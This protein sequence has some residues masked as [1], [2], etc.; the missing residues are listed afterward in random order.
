L[1][2]RALALLLAAGA[3]PL[4]SGA[5][6]G[7]EVTGEVVGQDDDAVD[8]RIGLANRSAATVSAV[9]AEAELF[10]HVESRKLDAGLAPGAASALLFSLPLA[11]APPG[12]HAVTLRLEYQAGGTPG[13]PQRTHVQPAYVLLALGEN[14]AP[15]VRLTAPEAHMD[16]VGRWRVGL[17]SIDGAAH[18]VRLRVVLPRTLRADPVDSL[19]DVPASGRID[20][21][22]LLFRVDA[23]WEGPQGALLVAA[24]EG[25]EITRTTVATAVVRVGREPGRVARWRRALA[26]AMVLFFLAALALELRRYLR[27]EA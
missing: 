17:E 14:A 27:P 15:A 25:E 23:P 12:V 10:G 21:E 19:V 24:T 2:V 9:K 8:V 3:V 7:L 4:A 5:E 11:G 1:L 26:L 13:Q 18:R 6:P 22:L 16:S 20:A